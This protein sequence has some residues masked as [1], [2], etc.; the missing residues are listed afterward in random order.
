MTTATKAPFSFQTVYDDIELI[1]H[2][3][4]DAEVDENGPWT[5]VS[6][7]AIT[8]EGNGQNLMAL[9]DRYSLST[10]DERARDDF[11]ARCRRSADAAL[12]ARY[13]DMR[14]GA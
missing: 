6:V 12:W 1:V 7:V 10:L 2:Y 8:V 14:R 4:V 11:E 9:F 3:R 13:V 5:T